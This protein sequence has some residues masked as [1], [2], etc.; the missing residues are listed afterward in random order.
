MVCFYKRKL[1]ERVTSDYLRVAVVPR[2]DS[3]VRCRGNG[4]WELIYLYCNFE[5]EIEMISECICELVVDEERLF[6]LIDR[7]LE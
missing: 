2:L 3:L 6:L 1:G 5:R 7:G 4:R